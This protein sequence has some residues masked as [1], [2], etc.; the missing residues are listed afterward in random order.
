MST[1]ERAFP[2]VIPVKLPEGWKG[3]NEGI[4]ICAKKADWYDED[5]W[6]ASGRGWVLDVGTLHG[7]PVYVCVAV[8][9]PVSA[10][11]WQNP[12]ERVEFKTAQ[13]AAAWIQAWFKKLA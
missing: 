4:V 2:D 3:Y 6:Q 8:R 7:N 10:E 13:E 1:A 11:D 12:D 5:M 9:E